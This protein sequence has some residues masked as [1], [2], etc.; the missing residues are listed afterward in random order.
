MLHRAR[1]TSPTKLTITF[2]DSG[3]IDGRAECLWKRLSHT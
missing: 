2:A 3:K 1:N